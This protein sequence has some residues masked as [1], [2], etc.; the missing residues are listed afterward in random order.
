MI[1]FKVFR[2]DENNFTADVLAPVVRHS[3]GEGYNMLVRLCDEWLSGANRFNKKG[4][5]FF[6]TEFEGKILGVGGRCID[7]YLNDPGVVRVRHLYVLPE[8]RHVGVGSKLLK[9]IL[10]VPAGIFR[11]ITLRTDNPAARKFYEYHGFKYTGEGD[12]TH[13]FEL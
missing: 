2:F 10:D 12:V 8:W 7:P 1:P 3:T 9:S 11:K 6:G 5:A 4:E 13:E